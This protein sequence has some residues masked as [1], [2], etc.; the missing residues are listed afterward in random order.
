MPSA[1]PLAR[2]W[3][4]PRSAPSHVI[5]LCSAKQLRWARTRARD[6]IQW[7]HA[8]DRHRVSHRVLPARLPSYA[9][10]IL[11]LQDIENPGASRSCCAF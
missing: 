8:G 1:M 3:R 7:P 6:P 11:R 10:Y 5:A 4:Q 2:A 9:D